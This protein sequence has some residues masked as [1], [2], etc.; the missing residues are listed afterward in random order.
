MYEVV[1]LGSSIPQTGS[2]AVDR[3]SVSAVTPWLAVVFRRQAEQQ[4]VAD[5][6]LGP[7]AGPVLLFG[8]IPGTE[9]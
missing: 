5:T 2:N 1:Q 4:K 7:W 8:Q 6:E 9:P 3:S